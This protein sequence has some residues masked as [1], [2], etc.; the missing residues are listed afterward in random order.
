MSTLVTRDWTGM[1][2]ADRS[3]GEAQPTAFGHGCLIGADARGDRML[4]ERAARVW[5]R[6]RQKAPQIGET[7]RL[8][9]V[10]ANSCW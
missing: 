1:F 9:A 7:D 3:P 4:S 6:G 5:N 10:L 2:H 8:P